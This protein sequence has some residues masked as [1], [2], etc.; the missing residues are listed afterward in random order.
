MIVKAKANRKEHTL[1]IEVKSS[2]E[3]RNIA[4]VAGYLSAMKSTISGYPVLVAPFISLRGRKMCKELGLGFVDLS[5]NA[6]LKFGSVLIERMGK[7]SR[8]KEKRLQ[9]SLFTEKSTWVIRKMFSKQDHKWKIEELAR[10]SNVS[11]GQA[12]KV[13]NKLE[14]EG[15]VDKKRGAITLLKPKELL[16]EWVKVYKFEDQSTTGYY[17]A[18]KEQED[19]FKALRKLSPNQYALTLGAAASLIAPFVRSTDV[20]MYIRGK[21]DMVVKALKLKPVEFGGN[22]YLI[23]PT[24]DAV[25]YDTQRIKGLTLVSNLQLYLDLYNYPMRGREQAEHLRNELMRF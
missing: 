4:Q 7:E 12:Y 18:N 20:Y 6:Y 10:E 8:A 5:G 15:F 2:G 19:I 14:A 23:S 11:L 13:I 21:A 3:P 24:N 16:D 17:C 1:I 9:K 22:I 25:L